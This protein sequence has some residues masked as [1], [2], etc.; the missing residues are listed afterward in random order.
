MEFCFLF[1]LGYEG[2]PVLFHSH[3]KLLGMEIVKMTP[4]KPRS[5]LLCW[6]S[7]S[8]ALPLVAGSL[9]THREVPELAMAVTCCLRRPVL[10]GLVYCGRFCWLFLCESFSL[11]EL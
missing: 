8:A 6:I 5:H 4:Q 3:Y 9:G 1:S 7:C 2:L 11:T 10:E